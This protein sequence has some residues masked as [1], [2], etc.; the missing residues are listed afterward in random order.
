MTTVEAAGGG[1]APVTG[2]SMC[3]RRVGL[4]WI[5][6]G[7]GAWSNIAGRGHGAV[8]V[9][10]RGGGG[11]V[12]IVRWTSG[13]RW[14]NR[15]A[16]G[17]DNN[18]NVLGHGWSLVRWSRV[19]DRGDWELG[20]ADNLELWGVVD[21]AVAVINLQVVGALWEV[22]LWGPQEGAGGKAFW[23]IC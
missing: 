9:D 23:N 21:I 22:G 10:H 18:S 4:L 14:N 1:V 3:S 12:S 8:G 16:G 15:G 20:A 5:L 19:W 7:S 17:W 11:H 6:T 13:Q 2:V